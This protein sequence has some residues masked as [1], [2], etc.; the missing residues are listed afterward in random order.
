M[1]A[2]HTLPLIPL[3]SR[4]SPIQLTIIRKKIKQKIEEMVFFRNCIQ[5]KLNIRTVNN[6]YMHRSIDSVDSLS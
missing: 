6:R 4:I 2:L 5:T 3:N 1:I